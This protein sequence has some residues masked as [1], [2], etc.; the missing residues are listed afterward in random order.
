MTI[1]GSILG[2]FIALVISYSLIR[3]ADEFEYDFRSEL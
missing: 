2:V 1:F 3:L